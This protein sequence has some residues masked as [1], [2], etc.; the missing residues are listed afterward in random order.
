MMIA[1]W[2]YQKK[3][4]YLSKPKKI[5]GLYNEESVMDLFNFKNGLIFQVF[6]YLKGN[7]NLIFSNQNSEL[8]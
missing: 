1:N 6:N 8:I 7:I 5:K 3:S 4:F 2:I